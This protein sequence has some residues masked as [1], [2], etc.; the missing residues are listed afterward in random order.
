MNTLT[1]V[2]KQIQKAAALHMLQ[3][4]IPHT[5]VLSTSPSKA[6]KI[7][8]YLYE[9]SYYAITAC[10]KKPRAYDNSCGSFLNK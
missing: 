7:L 8:Q 2:K 3:L 5:V 1:L 10:G 9:L 6:L 4:L